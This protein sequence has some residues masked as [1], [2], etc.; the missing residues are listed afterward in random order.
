MGQD[1]ELRKEQNLLEKLPEKEFKICAAL[2]RMN[3][4]RNYKLGVIE[5]LEWKD[6]IVKLMPEVEIEAIDFVI[7]KLIIGELHYEP[8]IGIRNIVIGLKNIEKEN[9]EFRVKPYRPW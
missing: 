8:N 2:H 7:D 3:Q 6:S 9:G 1:L 4:L 5:I